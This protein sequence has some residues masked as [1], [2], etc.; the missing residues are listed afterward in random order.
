[1]VMS[2]KASLDEHLRPTPAEVRKA[3]SRN[4]CRCA[5]YRQILH[6]IMAASETMSH[7]ASTLPRG[8]RAGGEG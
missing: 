8:K 1:L 6:A 2:A 5:G 4:L 3:I 7:Q